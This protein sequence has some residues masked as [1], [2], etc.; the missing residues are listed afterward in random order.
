MH[1]TVRF[2]ISKFFGVWKKLIILFS[3]D[4]SK[5]TVKTLWWYKR[6]LFQIN[7]VL[8]KINLKKNASWFTHNIKQ[9]NCF[10]LI[11]II[12]VSWAYCNNISHYY[13][14]YCKF[15]QINIALVS[16][17]TQTFDGTS[18][19]SWINIMGSFPITVNQK[20]NIEYDTP[21]TLI[22][23]LNWSLYQYV[24]I[25]CSGPLQQIQLII[26]II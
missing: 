14:I 23:R 15:D 9:H 11:I 26:L 12:N 8:H 18:K 25:I 3:K 7:A 6:F 13:S 19:I 20:P 17:T 21:L 4:T 16:I 24:L 22:M 10:Q 2:W 5:V 1:Y